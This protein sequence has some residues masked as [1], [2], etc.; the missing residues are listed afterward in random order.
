MP[1]VL[2][3]R[4]WQNI[5]VSSAEVFSTPGCEYFIQLSLTLR[6]AASSFGLNCRAFARN[7]SSCTD[8]TLPA[9]LT[10]RML[11]LSF[12]LAARD[13][14]DSEPPSGVVLDSHICLSLGA[15]LLVP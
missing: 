4:E 12:A 14:G 15:A 11:R 7:S 6:R 5:Q 1:V 13:H 2:S 10:A 8:A 3:A 9:T